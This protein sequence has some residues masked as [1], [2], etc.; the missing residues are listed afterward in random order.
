MPPNPS[1]DSDNP[2]LTRKAMSKQSKQS[3]ACTHCKSLKVRCE[4]SPDE[5]VCQRCQAGNHECIARSRKKR[6]PAPSQEDLQNTADEQDHKIQVLLERIDQMKRDIR[7]QELMGDAQDSGN[8]DHESPE[9]AAIAFFSQGGRPPIHSP[10]PPIIRCCSLY[11]PEII[12]LFDIYFKQV[13]PFFSLL[14]HDLHGNPAHLIWSSPFLFTVICTAASRFYTAKPNL[15]LVAHGLA[16]EAAAVALIH[17]SIGLDICQAYLILAVYPL[18]RKKFADDRSWL[19]MGIAIKMALEL[20]LNRPE[21]IPSPFS[22][23]ESLN[24]TRTWLNCYCVDASHGIQFGKMPMLNLEDYAARTSRDWYR[25]SNLNGPFDVH[26]CAYVSIILLMAEWKRTVAENCSSD[27]VPAAIQAQNKLALEM[28][29]WA[30]LYKQELDRYPLQ[31]CVYR[32]NTTKMITAYLRLVILAHAFQYAIKKGLSRNS[33]ILV[34]S[35]EAARKVIYIVL[36]KLHPTGNLRH[37]MDANFVYVSFASA[38]LVNLL[39][40]QFHALLEDATRKDISVL[41]RRLIQVLGSDSVGEKHTPALYSRFLSSLLVKYTD[42]S[43]EPCLTHN[44]WPD[45]VAPPSVEG[46]YEFLYQHHGDPEMDL[47]LGNF[48]R[49]VSNGLGEYNNYEHARILD[50]WR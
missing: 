21:P 17:G 38:F 46:S 29:R 31:I 27:I 42:S 43:E 32:G 47:S 33:E 44:P 23:K 37:A 18:P 5:A 15:Y 13:N 9:K 34:L 16:L 6:K 14:D 22:E 10:L 35:M 28:D 26:L 45:I 11:P 30:V 7:I 12:T 20:G 41:V 3:G 48:M 1:D 2:P 24:R 49:A 4:F 8:A 39:R 36:D 19:F 50:L 25:S 40:P